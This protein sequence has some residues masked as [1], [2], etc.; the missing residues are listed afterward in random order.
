M[1]GSGVSPAIAFATTRCSARRS[2]RRRKAR[3]PRR[4][5]ASALP[6]R[7]SPTAHR[8][9]RVQRRRGSRRGCRALLGRGTTAFVQE[10]RRPRP[11]ANASAPAGRCRM[12]RRRRGDVGCAIPGDREEHAAHVTGSRPQD[13]RVARIPP[14]GAEGPVRLV[15]QV[16]GRGGSHDVLV[17]QGPPP[18]G[19][20]NLPV[21]RNR[22]IRKRNYQLLLHRRRSR[23]YQTGTAVP[24][25]TASSSSASKANHPS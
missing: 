1:R 15:C 4:R 8:P 21:E 12:L 3:Q 13:H 6:R 5:G 25:S 16:D 24:V 20:S 7:Q 2:H 19:Y 17:L 9:R 18:A 14:S 11:S 22:T 10:R 23:R